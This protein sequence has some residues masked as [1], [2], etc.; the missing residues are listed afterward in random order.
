MIPVEV[1]T[2]VTED[3]V[4]YAFLI[5]ADPMGE[6]LAHVGGFETED[7]AIEAAYIRAAEG[8]YQVSGVN[9]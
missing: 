5:E 7:Q 9:P 4:W 8:D 2:G 3:L 1:F 6:I